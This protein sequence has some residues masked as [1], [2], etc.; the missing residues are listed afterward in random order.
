MVTLPK[1]ATPELIGFFP[2]RLEFKNMAEFIGKAARQRVSPFTW[3]DSDSVEIEGDESFRSVHSYFAESSGALSA[4][5]HFIH[6]THNLAAGEQQDLLR[7]LD[8]VRS[9]AFY[10]DMK[11]VEAPANIT[12]AQVVAWCAE[13]DEGMLEPIVHLSIFEPI[14][15][16]D[17]LYDLA[18]YAAQGCLL[19]RNFESHRMHP[20]DLLALCDSHAGPHQWSTHG[21]ADVVLQHTHVIVLVAAPIGS[22]YPN[23]SFPAN[24]MSEQAWQHMISLEEDEGSDEDTLFGDWGAF[25]II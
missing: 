25:F 24:V 11:P 1:R 5:Q 14:I 12:D 4:I 7:A 8:S 18:A 15:G 21:R 3:S 20:L 16:G 17:G 22:L 9:R 6:S 13:N 23:A 19:F 10:T 2:N